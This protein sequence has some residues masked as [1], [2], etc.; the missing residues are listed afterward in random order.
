MSTAAF[1]SRSLI[2]PAV[3]VSETWP[4]VVITPPRMM[5]VAESKRMSPVPVVTLEVS[6]AVIRFASRS[7]VPVEEVV[8]F[9]V[10]R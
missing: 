4:V 10:L 8:M 6:D 5:S 9:R 1:T 7:T 3:A 2:E